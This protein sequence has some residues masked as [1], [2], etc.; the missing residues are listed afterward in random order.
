VEEK[1]AN[2]KARKKKN[3]QENRKE[4]S[5]NRQNECWKDFF[6]GSFF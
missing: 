1:E 3:K 5:K 6:F 4:I 2:K